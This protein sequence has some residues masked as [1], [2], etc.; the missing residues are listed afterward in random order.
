MPLWNKVKE[1]FKKIEIGEFRLAEKV[2]EK[3]EIALARILNV[4]EF[5]EKYLDI[6]TRLRLR[7]TCSLFREIIYEKRLQIDY[8]RYTCSGNSIEIYTKK[9]FKVLYESIHGKLRVTNGDRVRVINA[10]NETEKIEIIQRDL[11]SILGSKKLRI[12]TIRIEHQ[13]PSHFVDE[14]CYWRSL[15]SQGEQPL[16]GMI[17]L[18]NTF[19]LVPNKVKISKLEYCIDEETDVF[20]E[21]MKTID[22]DHLQFFQLIR[23]GH[24]CW[25]PFVNLYNLEQWRRLKSLDVRCPQLTVSNIIRFY[26]H[27]ENAHLN[28]GSFHDISDETPLQNSIMM[29]KDKLLQNPNL[30]Q[31]KVKSRYCMSDTDFEEINASLQQY[32]TNNAPYQC[33]VSIPY[34]DSDKK[35][36]LLVKKR[37]I[38]F[39]GPCY[40]EEEVKEENAE[41]IEDDDW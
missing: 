14:Y 16:T 28:I 10:K 15:G 40:V 33:W 19:N 17:A 32:N 37:I 29:I 24:D 9:G 20:I 38:W 4:P 31:F 11:M 39:K 36:Q 26:T 6:D 25:T 2:E 23:S 27:F 12:D 35:L 21:T 34:P 3:A 41:E 1:F 13:R 30:K 8:L 22:P 18:Q 5:V 7:K